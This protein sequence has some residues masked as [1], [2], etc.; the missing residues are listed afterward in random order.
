MALFLDI[1]LIIFTTNI[2]NHRSITCDPHLH[3]SAGSL[4]NTRDALFFANAAKKVV[5]RPQVNQV[6]DDKTLIKRMQAEIDGL[7]KQLVR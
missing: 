1:N 5:M 6:L 3:T 7:K 2:I 4:D